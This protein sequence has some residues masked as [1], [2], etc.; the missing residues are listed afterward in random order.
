M[1]PEKKENR[2]DIAGHEWAKLVLEICGGLAG[3]PRWEVRQ[4]DQILARSTTQ[5]LECD[6]NPV[7]NELAACMQ[8]ANRVRMFQSISLHF[9]ARWFEAH[10]GILVPQ[11]R[12]GMCTSIFPVPWCILG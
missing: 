8:N 3:F 7:T 6:G 4:G 1:K 5:I 9:L 12:A 11:P 2:L 10:L